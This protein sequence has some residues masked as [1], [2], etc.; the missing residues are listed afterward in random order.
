MDP[1]EQQ[2]LLG[3]VHDFSVSTVCDK[4]ELFWS[5]HLMS[6]KWLEILRVAISYFFKSEQK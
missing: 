5:R 6:F 4:R 3:E 2:L 1:A